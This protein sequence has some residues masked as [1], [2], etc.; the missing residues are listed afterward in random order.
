MRK[1]IAMLT[2]L[3]PFSPDVSWL[4]NIYMTKKRDEF[5]PATKR[6]LAERVAWRC[7]FPGCQKITIGPKSS[8][9]EKSINNGIAAHIH[10]AAKCGPRPNP[11]MTPEERSYI[12][13]GIWMCRDHGNLIDADSSEYSADTLRLWKAEAERIAADNL[14]I[15][16]NSYARDSADTLLQLGSQIIFNAEWESCSPTK[17]EF[18]LKEPV[19]G[20]LEALKAYVLSFKENASESFVI[21][22]SQGDARIIS[23]VEFKPTILSLSVNGKITPTNPNHL[24]RSYTRTPEKKW[25]ETNGIDTAISQLGHCLSTVKGE[26]VHNPEFGSLATVYYHK[27][28]ENLFLLSRL[29][30]LEMIRLSLIPIYGSL[31]ATDNKEEPPLRFVERFLDV[32][33][34][35]SELVD[36]R[37]NVNVSLQWKDSSGKSENWSGTLQVF[38]LNSRKPA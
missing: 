22:E 16:N 18:K 17:W 4:K 7:S 34:K 24:G 25:V 29:L 9:V 23:G 32:N 20:D 28:K 3:T 2:P 8:D 30:K 15:P 36:S 33:V 26:V 10:A 19:S 27:Y 1:H 6:V 5:T 13:N 37:L 12:T 11:N 38:I 14:K 35:S 31:F 21:I